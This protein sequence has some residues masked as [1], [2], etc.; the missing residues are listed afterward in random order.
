MHLTDKYPKGGT[1]TWWGFSSCMKKNNQ[2]EKRL[3]LNK[4]GKRTLFVINCYSGKDIHRHS[5]FENEVLLPPGRQFNVVNTVD[6]GNRLHIIELNEI[7]PSFDFLDVVLTSLNVSIDH[8][9]QN[10]QF[11]S[12]STVSLSKKSLPAALPNPYLEVRLAQFFK[13]P[14]KIDLKSMR[15]TDSD[16]DIIVSEIIIL[17]QCSEL[18]LSSNEIT[19]NGTLSLAHVLRENKVSKDV[20]YYKCTFYCSFFIFD[21]HLLHSISPTIRLEIKECNNS[22]RL[23]VPMK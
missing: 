4:T 15:L 12:I 5:V 16:M 22:A 14:R 21:R 10:I 20:S 8:P 7:Q 2:L 13:Q 18:N 17:R 1:I 23:Y 9:T 3:F 19:Y 11:E 6:V